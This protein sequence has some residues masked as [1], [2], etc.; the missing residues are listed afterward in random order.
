MQL[1]Q[2]GPEHIMQ[3]SKV[4]NSVLKCLISDKSGPANGLHHM[5]KKS[6]C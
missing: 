3:T 2:D 4:L 1:S 6:P 5:L